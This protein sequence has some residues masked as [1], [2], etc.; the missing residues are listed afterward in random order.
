MATATLRQLFPLRR[1]GPSHGRRAATLPSERQRRR[2]PVYLRLHGDEA[3]SGTEARTH[4]DVSDRPNDAPGDR[5]DHAG[6]GERV[7]EAA[8]VDH[9][10][11]AAARSDDDPA[12]ARRAA[13]RATRSGATRR[14]R[15]RRVAAAGRPCLSG[16]GLRRRRGG[17]F[18]PPSTRTS[19]SLLARPAAV[20]RIGG[21]PSSGKSRSATRS[22]AE[23]AWH[24][25]RS[26]ARRASSAE[27]RR[28]LHAR[29]KPSQGA[30]RCRS[31]GPSS[32]RRTLR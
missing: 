14:S 21:P 6:V 2:S 18:S 27:I 32:P 17:A 7:L 24:P 1:T 22:L 3:L 10:G 16:G 4:D 11:V 28:R 23:P 8:A 20:P 12:R 5:V 31:G 25:R 29:A 13:T 26:C 19:T 15:V 30:A 9:A